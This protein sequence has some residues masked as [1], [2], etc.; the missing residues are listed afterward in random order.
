MNFATLAGANSYT[1]DTQVT[2]G[3]LFIASVGTLGAAGGS[4]TVS[5]SGRLDLRNQ[6]VRTGTISM[7][8]QNASIVSGDVN[9]PGSIVNN[10]VAFQFGGGLLSAPVSGSAGFNVTGGGSIT[11]SNS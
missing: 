3:T 6:Q 9:N 11:G 1:G 10:G 4:V 7:V 8:G 2:S 5:G